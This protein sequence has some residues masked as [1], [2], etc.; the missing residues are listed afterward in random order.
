[1]RF[2]KQAWY[3][4]SIIGMLFLLANFTLWF[5][6]N[7]AIKSLLLSVQGQLADKGLSFSYNDTIFNTLTAWHIEG[8][9]QNVEIYATSNTSSL[10]FNIG[11]VAIDSNWFD[12]AFI[13]KLPSEIPA[14][15]KFLNTSQNEEVFPLKF[16]A[17]NPIQ[18]KVNLNL[19]F[20]IGESKSFFD[21]INV[22]NQIKNLIVKKDNDEILI[23]QGIK[24]NFIPNIQLKEVLN[25]Q[26]FNAQ[27]YDLDKIKN[28]DLGK[29]QR[30]DITTLEK[31]S[32]G[33]NEWLL[34]FELN[35]IELSPTAIEEF[36]KYSSYI[37]D[38][39]IASFKTKIR[40]IVNIDKKNTEE[41]FNLG[42][43]IPQMSIISNFFSIDGHGN[44]F[45]RMDEKEKIENHVDFSINIQ[46]YNHLIDFYTDLI[47]KFILY[48]KVG[49]TFSQ[50]EAD[51]LKKVIGKIWKVENENLQ[52][53]LI[54]DGN[55][56]MSISGYTKDQILLMAK[57]EA[58]NLQQNN[59]VKTK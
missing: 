8:I 23:L 21:I 27:D 55:E 35:H 9:I 51:A 2:I 50:K 7:K 26:D 47:N 17:D 29:G 42:Y 56:D 25:S 38:M 14:L 3:L 20:K 10:Y 32:Q 4:I 16:L 34:N 48:Y 24:C 44:S 36:A 33:Y 39:G 58:N 43:N 1:M 19:H 28:T 15:I 49:T 18:L 37:K 57:Q 45:G 12:K 11:D 13:T 31:I 54:Q 52:L 22:E 53:R 46:N 59:S 41:Y 30:H 6:H 40:R 5:I